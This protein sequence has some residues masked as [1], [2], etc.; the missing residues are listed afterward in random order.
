MSGSI[1]GHDP[2]LRLGGRHHHSRRCLGIRLGIRE[3]AFGRR[4]TSLLASNRGDEKLRP[5]RILGHRHTQRRSRGTTVLDRE[6]DGADDDVHEAPLLV[7][8]R[9][10]RLP[11]LLPSASGAGPSERS[12]GPIRSAAHHLTPHQQFITTSCRTSVP[13][14]G[15]RRDR[16][17]LPGRRDGENVH[18]KH[19]TASRTPRSGVAAAWI[20]R[21][22]PS[23][24]TY[25]Y[26]R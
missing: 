13:H 17:G 6:H 21:L 23:T 25:G 1:Q 11:G 2:R 3:G 20:P 14:I 5:L 22:M 12:A 7:G 16:E 10:W 19:E 9:A 24:G 15:A 18:R 8:H 26:M 4:S